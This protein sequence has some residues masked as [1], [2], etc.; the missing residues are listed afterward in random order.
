MNI[1]S[2]DYDRTLMSA[3]SNLIGLYPTSEEKLDQLLFELEKDENKW[4]EDIPYQPIPVHTVSQSI[5]Y[6]Y[7]TLFFFFSFEEFS[8]KVMGVSQCPYFFQLVENIRNGEQIQ[9]VSRQ[10]RVYTSLNK[11]F[12]SNRND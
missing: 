2:T 1:R 6:V 3:Y 8:L 4:P 10:W 12:S 11:E 7:F 9:N 5:D